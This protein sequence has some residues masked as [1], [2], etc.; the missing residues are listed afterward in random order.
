MKQERVEQIREI[1]EEYRKNM[2]NNGEIVPKSCVYTDLAL[3]E[4]MG[5]DMP[6]LEINSNTVRKLE[7]LGFKVIYPAELSAEEIAMMTDEERYEYNAK[8]KNPLIIDGKETSHSLE[9]AKMISNHYLSGNKQLWSFD[10]E[11]NSLT[12]HIRPSDYKEGTVENLEKLLSN[13]G[14]EPAIEE[15]EE[16]HYKSFTISSDIPYPA[17]KKSKLE[18]IYDKAK[19]KIQ[20]VFA[21]LKALVNQ[22]DQVKENDTNERE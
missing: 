2:Q 10:K 13:V 19:G 17:V 20:G 12:R 14:I 18:Q 22:K 9:F 7:S 16:Y 3:K 5:F 21:K 15:N 1:L 8:I 4:N 6:G 11:N